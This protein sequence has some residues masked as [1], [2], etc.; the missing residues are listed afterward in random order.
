MPP[1]GR[2]TVTETPDE[3]ARAKARER[4]ARSARAGQAPSDLYDAGELEWAFAG[5]HEELEELEELA[6][7]APAAEAEH[8]SSIERSRE[9]EAAT[10]RVLAEFDAEEAAKRRAKAQ[11]EARRRLGWK[12]DERP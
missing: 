7:Q 1:L 10:D 2:T 4:V 6:A 12:K 9:L 5:V 11:A 3:V 8:R